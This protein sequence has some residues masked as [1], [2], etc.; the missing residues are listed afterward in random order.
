[1]KPTTGVS[2]GSF[3]GSKVEARAALIKY[4]RNRASP[5]TGRQD[6][7]LPALL[8]RTTTVADSSSILIFFGIFGIAN[9][10]SAPASGPP[11]VADT[12]VG[13]IASV[14]NPKSGACD[15]L[16]GGLTKL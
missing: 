14:R 7:T 13:V 4:D 10:R 3:A 1:M 11:A 16:S 5:T 6:I 15:L 9:L 8:T 12:L 2:L